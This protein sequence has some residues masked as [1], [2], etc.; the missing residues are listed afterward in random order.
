MC[1]HQAA[2][3]GWHLPEPM[4]VR[5]H[6]VGCY[7]ISQAW[8][9]CMPCIDHIWP[10]RVHIMRTMPFKHYAPY[11]IF[12]CTGQVPSHGPRFLS[13]FQLPARTSQRPLSL[14]RTIEQPR[15]V[16]L[17]TVHHTPDWTQH[18]TY[19]ISVLRSSRLFCFWTM[20]LNLSPCFHKSKTSYETI[21]SVYVRAKSC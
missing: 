8:L 7:L 5:A 2:P 10:Q 11:I 20:L 18:H 6:A 21:Q 16:T 19:T 3:E 12:F 1:C 15:I 9:P 14:N 13:T 4:F 17:E